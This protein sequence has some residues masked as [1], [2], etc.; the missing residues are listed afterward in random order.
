MGKASF[1]AD[2]I[3]DNAAEL[4]ATVV[5]LK[6]ASAKGEYI[7]SITISTTMSPGVAVDKTSIAGI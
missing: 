6:P 4:I 1:T 5:K 2:K 7:R 3:K